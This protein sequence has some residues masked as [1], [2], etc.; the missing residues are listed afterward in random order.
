MARPRVF[1]SSTCY[2]LKHIRSSLEGMVRN[3]GFEPILSEKGH[4]AFAPDAPLDESCYREVGSSDIYVMIIGGRYGSERSGTSDDGNEEPFWRRYKS[5]T[6]AEYDR[7]VE[8]DIPIYVLIERAVYAEYQTFLNNKSNRHIQYAHVDS[9][10]VFYLIDSILAKRRNNPLHE[11]DRFPDIES[12]LREQW[13]G[14][15]RELLARTH[16]QRELTD[17]STQVAE[18]AE[19]NNTLRAYLETIISKV[20]PDSSEDVIRREQDRLHEAVKVATLHNNPYIT[21]V[22][23]AH[24]KTTKEVKEALEASES[25]KDFAEILGLD[26]PGA[27]GKRA[28]ASLN[29]ARTFLGLSEYEEPDDDTENG[30]SESSK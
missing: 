2:D 16:S 13:S 14:L 30:D 9:I 10:N 12:W 26:C 4:I 29:D 21:H 27:Y 15:F 7:A 8:A 18:L 17:L 11:F 25:V 23:Q 20:A 6:E 1:I 19:V 24:G 22:R 28:V 5:I 3:M